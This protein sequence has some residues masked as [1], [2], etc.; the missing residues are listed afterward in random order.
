MPPIPVLEDTVAPTAPASGSLADPI[1]LPVPELPPLPAIDETVADNPDPQETPEVVTATQAEAGS[2]NVSVRVLS[3]GADRPVTQKSSGDDVVSTSAEPDITAATNS[4]TVTAPAASQSTGVN[5]NVEIRVLSP[6][7]NGAVTQTSDSAEVTP[8]DETGTMPPSEAEPSSEAKPTSSASGDQASVTPVDSERY[9]EENSQYQSASEPP[10]D[11]W[12]WQ[13]AFAIDCAG[14]ATSLSTESGSQASLIWTWDWAWNWACIGPD[15]GA[16][17]SSGS[18]PDSSPAADA[19][20]TNVSVRVLSPGDNGPVTQSSTAVGEAAGDVG[21]T[22]A[23]PSAGPWSWTWTFTFC[24]TTRSFSTQIASQTALSWTWDWAWNWTCDAAVGAPPT[25]GAATQPGAGAAP[26]SAQS[27][28]IPAVQAPL[29]PPPV[30]APP[31]VDVPPL[32]PLPAP[33]VVPSVDVA[34]DVIVEPVI[35][36]P[37]LPD[38]SLT[39]PAVPA[40]DAQVVMAPAEFPA[41]LARGP[42]PTAHAAEKASTGYRDAGS[43]T[44]TTTSGVAWQPRERPRSRRGSQPTAKRASAHVASSRLTRSLPPPFGQLRS[45]QGTGSGTLGGRV[46]EAPVLAVAALIAFFMLAA[47]SLGRRIRVARELSPR[48]TYRSSIDHPG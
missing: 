18:S 40:V 28:L 34:V 39:P 41:A 46:P 48:S 8:N 43:S 9:Q 17:S 3:P 1:P 11:P 25:L 13:W 14:N 24:G 27:T 5:T 2:I 45:S 12:N 32:P 42:R 15:S 20:N 37:A 26:V 7:D 36:A 44:P 35:L 19:G 6:G 22:G 47:P 16:T 4:E 31:A 23:A 10:L 29:S 33:P 38:V 30:P 21:A